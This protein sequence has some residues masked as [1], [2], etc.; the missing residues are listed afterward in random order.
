MARHGG[1]F[2]SG[3]ANPGVLRNE[4]HGPDHESKLRFWVG[5]G[6]NRTYSGIPQRL[7]A[8]ILTS[9]HLE[10]EVQ[11]LVTTTAYQSRDVSRFVLTLGIKLRQFYCFAA[12]ERERSLAVLPPTPMVAV[13][14]MLRLLR[15]HTYA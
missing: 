3:G 12:A 1:S 8:Y 11:S 15:P 14:P 2:T 7:V 9:P 5:R 6:R 13:F 10:P 4:L